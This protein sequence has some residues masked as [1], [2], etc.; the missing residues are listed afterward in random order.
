MARIIR[1]AFQNLS[2]EEAAIGGLDVPLIEEE[3][4]AWEAVKNAELALRRIIR[5]KYEARWKQQANDRMRKVLGEDAWATIEKVRQKE[6]SQY[7]L[8]PAA[9][10][11]DLLNYCYL[12][13][14][15]TLILSS[16]SWD[17]FSHV[18]KDKQQL[19]SLVKCIMPVRN[20]SAHFRPVPVKEL[21]RCRIASD[22][23]IVLLS[24]EKIGDLA[25]A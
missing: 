24:K 2:G 4:A 16:E 20:D 14:L 1:L 19:E 7:P 13:Q 25:S 9:N 17:L 5:A 6:A 10:N 15:V 8:S 11:H 12:G 22:D 3:K 21:Q 18:F 23:L